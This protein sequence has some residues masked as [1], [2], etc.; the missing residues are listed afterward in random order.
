MRT[1][2]SRRDGAYDAGVDE[3]GP[4]AEARA[5]G[6]AAL[7]AGRWQQARSQFE[8]AL[9]L[10]DTAEAWEGLSWAA[11]WLEDVSACIQARQRAYRG[12]QR[13]GDRRGAARMALWLGDD[14]L[15]FHGAEAVASG[16]FQRAAR[17][18]A[19]LDPSPEHGWLDVFEAH[20]A[21]DR[22]DPA[23]ALRLA[24]R[25]REQ[26]RRHGAVDLEMFSLASE[27]LAMIDQG[28]VAAGMRC[29]DEATAA[30]LAGEYEN[31]APAAWTCCRLISACELVRDYDRGA[32]WC[33][34]VTEFSLRMDARFV[35]G[36]C[37]AHYAAILTWR[38]EWTKAE[39]ELQA[40]LAGLADKRP[41]WLPEALVRLGELRRRQGRPEEAERLFTRVATH[42]LS[43][44][45]LA[46]IRL[47]T[48]DAAA[49]RDLLE[50]HLRQIPERS[51][52]SRTGPLELLVRA[53]LEL[54]DRPAAD[55]YLAE[56]QAAGSVV[57]TAPLRAA[58]RLSEGLVAA[59]AGDREQACDHFEDAVDL[60][61]HARAPFEEGQA[62]LELARAMQ[63]LGRTDAAAREAQAAYDCLE[64]VGATAAAARAREL[65]APTVAP[66]TAVGDAVLTDR[67]LQVLR[68]VADGLTDREIADRL[69]LSEHTVHRH[70]ANIYVRLGCSSRATAVAHAA[71]LG[72]L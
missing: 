33:H 19:E 60:F 48:G 16:W 57:A 43:Q 54:G 35:T 24:T 71:R 67:Q 13:R 26:G 66:A 47:D 14:H 37:R 20:A 49:A 10:A 46:R 41:A 63:A 22:H 30:A 36:V 42:P 2:R 50:R 62:R 44:L 64:R 39:Q 38:G 28:D 15:E 3:S 52:I 25:A 56:L 17:T 7:A 69:T 9:A 6:R 34:K 55:R 51:R 12:F 11:W 29:L 53:A 65:A 61:G 21:L 32:Q 1:G 72:L 68:L 40:A 4:A 45:G 18:L 27:G 58:V 70:V 59:A 31:L 5:A 8:Q 23:E